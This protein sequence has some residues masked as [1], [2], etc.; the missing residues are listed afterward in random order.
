MD[1]MYGPL[2]TATGPGG[3]C[4]GLLSVG[5]MNAAAISIGDAAAELA[6]WDQRVKN[7]ASAPSFAEGAVEIEER[8]E[9]RREVALGAFEG[10]AGNT[11]V[12][13]APVFSALVA[14]KAAPAFSW[15]R[16]GWSGGRS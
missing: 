6:A 11:P 7:G 9:E 14:S 2:V 1:E 4:S 3:A 15:L 10:G 12:F 5:L 13:D 16:A 8:R